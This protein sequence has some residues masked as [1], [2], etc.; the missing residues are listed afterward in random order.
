MFKQSQARHA[1]ALTGLIVNC[2]EQIQ[3]KSRSWAARAAKRREAPGAAYSDHLKSN[4]KSAKSEGNHSRRSRPARDFKMQ[5]PPHHLL[6]INS[7]LW[8][9]VQTPR[10]PDPK[11][12]QAALKQNTARLPFCCTDRRPE[13][14]TTIS[15]AAAVTSEATAGDPE[16]APATSCC[17]LSSRLRRKVSGASHTALAPF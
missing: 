14:Q 3:M 15:K 16:G 17:A 10:S 7:R 2:S 6:Y 12:R 11:C 9:T 4:K 5:E 1:T 8:R 13:K